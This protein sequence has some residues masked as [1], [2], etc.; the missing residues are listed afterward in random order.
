MSLPSTFGECLIFIA[1]GQLFRLLILNKPGCGHYVNVLVTVVLQVTLPCVLVRTLAGIKSFS[2]EGGVAIALYLVYVPVC[3]LIAWLW[4]RKKDPALLACFVTSSMAEN[5]GLFFYPI[6]EEVAGTEG[7]AMLALVDFPGPFFAFGLFPGIYR[8]AAN[9]RRALAQHKKDDPTAPAGSAIVLVTPPPASTSPDAPALPSASAT[10]ASA[11]VSAT[12]APTPSPAA[13]ISHHDHSHDDDNDDDDSSSSSSSSTSS[14]SEDE[15][16]V[17]EE[18]DTYSDLMWDVISV[19]DGLS[20]LDESDGEADARERRRREHGEEDRFAQYV[21]DLRARRAE[22]RRRRQQR[23]CGGRCGA[24]WRCAVPYLS[25]FKS[26]PLDSILVGIVLGPIAKCGLPRVLD[27]FLLIAARANTFASMALIGAML[28][29]RINAFREHWKSLL[30]I[31][32]IRYGVG[33]VTTLIA[34][35][36]IGPHFSPLA[37]MVFAVAYVLPTP[38]SA[39]SYAVKFG[40]D[41]ALPALA[42]NTTMIL[43]FFIS[44]VILIFVPPLPGAS[45][46]SA[47]DS[48]LS[49]SS[50][51]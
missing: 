27:D 25:L 44:W 6:M 19:D 2:V 37:R 34:Y 8:W 51:P 47:V 41:A 11:S 32:L 17:E 22:R 35:F 9:K 36:A 45:S 20:D 18:K 43:S 50:Q 39:G 13:T 38:V 33:A 15:E 4:Y 30:R 31:L 21:Q 1:I 3:G 40:I 28:D 16:E 46:S 12:P 14:S 48:S 10:P 42:I 23:V 29:V 49:L 24:C 7:I 26:M 5:I